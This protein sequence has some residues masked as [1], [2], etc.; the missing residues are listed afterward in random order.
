MPQSP[1]TAGNSPIFVAAWSSTCDNLT[2]GLLVKAEVA[3]SA[4]RGQWSQDDPCL[5]MR[6]AVAYEG[7]QDWSLAIDDPRYALEYCAGGEDW[8]SI[9]EGSVQHAMM[10]G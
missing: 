2:H 3:D 4:D 10:A 7:R 1:C 9:C 5:W 8:L 6:N